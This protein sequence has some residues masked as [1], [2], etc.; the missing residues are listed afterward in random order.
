MVKVIGKTLQK[1]IYTHYPVLSGE[2]KNTRPLKK[3]SNAAPKIIK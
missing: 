3:L 2:H 1:I